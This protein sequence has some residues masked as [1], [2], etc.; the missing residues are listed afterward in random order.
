M[1]FADQFVLNATK[2]ERR[3]SELSVDVRNKGVEIVGVTQGAG[4]I[5]SFL[6]IALNQIHAR[7]AIPPIAVLFRR[8]ECAGRLESI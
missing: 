6:I 2:T 1:S 8:D 4:D 3:C 7:R 5:P